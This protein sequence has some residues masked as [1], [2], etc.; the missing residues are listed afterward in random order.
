[1]VI[2]QLL[3][4]LCLHVFLSSCPTH[5]DK[6]T[7]CRKLIKKCSCV[8]RR[9]VVKCYVRFICSSYI[10]NYDCTQNT[11]TNALWGHCCI[12]TVSCLLVSSAGLPQ[13]VL[14]EIVNVQGFASLS[15]NLLLLFSFSLLLASLL[16][17]LETSN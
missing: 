16:F 3:C 4:D 11:I 2:R 6:N 10:L 14:A 5:E 17:N 1:M 15:H 9:W 12:W 8:G 13:L 7:W